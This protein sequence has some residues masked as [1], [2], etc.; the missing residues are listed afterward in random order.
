MELDGISMDSMKCIEGSNIVAPSSFLV[1]KAIGASAL[2]GT[3]FKGIR[4]LGEGLVY[5]IKGRLI[6]KN[7]IVIMIKA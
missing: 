1:V 2:T 3:F 6:P 5:N 4:D 7:P